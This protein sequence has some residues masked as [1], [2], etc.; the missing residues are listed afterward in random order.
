VTDGLDV[1]KK[2][3]STKTGQMDRP[4]EDV[5]MKKVTIVR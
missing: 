3:G 2:I 4:V 5:V 1:I